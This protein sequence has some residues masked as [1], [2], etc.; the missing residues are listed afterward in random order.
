M[1]CFAYAQA[2]AAAGAVLQLLVDDGLVEEP[3][4]LRTG[5]GRRPV[6]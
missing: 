6:F 2:Y 4:E 3:L 5:A 1:L